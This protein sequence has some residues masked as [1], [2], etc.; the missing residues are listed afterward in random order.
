[1][2]IVYSNITDLMQGPS[3]GENSSNGLFVTRGGQTHTRRDA[4]LVF[5]EKIHIKY[6]NCD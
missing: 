1:M 6:E 2:Y 3:D 4:S 5:V